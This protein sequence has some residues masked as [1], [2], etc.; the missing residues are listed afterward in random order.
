MKEK[1]QFNPIIDESMVDSL[2]EEKE[3]LRSGSGSGSGSG[4]DGPSQTIIP[5]R[6]TSTEITEQTG[7]YI[8]AA[9]CTV[10]CTVT[11]TKR[12]GFDDEIV[13]TDLNCAFKGPRKDNIVTEIIGENE[14]DV[15]YSTLAE[16]KNGSGNET[17]N[18]ACVCTKSLEYIMT[19]DLN[20]TYSEQDKNVRVEFSINQFLTEIKLSDINISFV[21]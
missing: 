11:I 19:E 8:F 9:S 16:E 10:S 3:I 2:N 17:I 7:K 21:S 18:H 20:H 6:K 1:K 5:L 14:K 13:I 4:S 15:K 12:L